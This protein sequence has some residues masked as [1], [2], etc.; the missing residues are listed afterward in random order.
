MAFLALRLTY[1]LVWEFPSTCR[2]SDLRPRA[3]SIHICDRYAPVV[4]FA[5]TDDL[6]T[7]T[8]FFI[9]NVV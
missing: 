4:H 1:D 7:I 5:Y 2:M 3:L 9:G 6:A 8:M